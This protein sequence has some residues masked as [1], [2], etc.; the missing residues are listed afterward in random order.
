M[1]ALRAQG[2]YCF[3]IH[4]GPTMVAGLPD[5]ICCAEG[6]FVGLETKMPE[7]RNNVS[8][9]QTYVHDQIRLAGGKVYVVCDP[10]EAVSSVKL[11]LFNARGSR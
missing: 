7:S 10:A 4:G 1:D 2:W 9:R 6:L 3:K 11:A 5:I 8:A